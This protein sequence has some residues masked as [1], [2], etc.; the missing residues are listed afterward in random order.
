MVCINQNMVKNY[1][2]CFNLCRHRY[3]SWCVLSFRFS[4]V[5]N[6]WKYRDVIHALKYKKRLMSVAQ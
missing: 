4:D 2:D 5:I 1:Y 6:T 3:S